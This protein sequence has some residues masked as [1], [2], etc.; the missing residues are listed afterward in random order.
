MRAS[1]LRKHVFSRL[2]F[3]IAFGFGSG[4]SPIVPGTFGTLAAIPLYYLLI[5]LSPW[6]YL[7][8]VIL[9]FALG[10]KVC[11]TVSHELGV[12]DFSGIVWDEIVG[13]LIT[14]FCVPT[15]ILWV[16]A[17]FCLFRFFD[18][19]KPGPITWVDEAV[20]GGLGI[21]LDDVAAAIPALIILQGCAFW[22]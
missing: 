22:A 6:W 3:F 5:N 15:G 1:N 7:T 2:D 20:G 19:V 4:L 13:F 8:C 12:H 16:V 18:I 21:M 14:M 11:D 17:G 10:V 9:A